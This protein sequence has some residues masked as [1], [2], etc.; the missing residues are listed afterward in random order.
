[1]PLN[2]ETKFN[3][4][5]L[6]LHVQLKSIF[7]IILSLWNL[8][9]IS[10]FSDVFRNYQWIDIQSVLKWTRNKRQQDTPHYVTLPDRLSIYRAQIFF[11]YEKWFYL[12]NY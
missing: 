1:M 3:N 11:K 5:C 10:K 2:F 9:A 4:C 8:V 7:T 12:S 6:Q